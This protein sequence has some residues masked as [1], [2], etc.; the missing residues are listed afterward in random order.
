M[1]RPST[2]TMKSPTIPSTILRSELNFAW[3][4]ATGS[5][6]VR[7][8]KRAFE[9]IRTAALAHVVKLLRAAERISH[10]HNRRVLGPAAIHL[11]RAML[12]RGI[13]KLSKLPPHRLLSDNCCRSIARSHGMSLSR[14]TSADPLR[15]FDS[16]G[17]IRRFL[18]DFIG[19]FI[20]KLLE[21]SPSMIRFSE[22]QQALVAIK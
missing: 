14:R 7:I 5:A 2:K 6:A 19:F 8:E 11:A 17:E 20:G 18:H 3:Q 21:S 4:S 15:P 16:C 12:F 22:T 10:L 13:P 1:S 9:T